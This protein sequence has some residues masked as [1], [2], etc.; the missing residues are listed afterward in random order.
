MGLY[1]DI[2]NLTQDEM[3]AFAKLYN[4]YSEAP[5]NYNI[6]YIYRLYR[7][8]EE[9]KKEYKA[10]SWNTV[11]DSLESMMFYPIHLDFEA[12]EQNFKH[13]RNMM[14]TVAGTKPIGG[15]GRLVCGDD[16]LLRWETGEELL[17]E[18]R[19]PVNSIIAYFYM[20]P[21]KPNKS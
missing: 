12:F 3:E 8:Y 14:N 18:E 20:R 7:K 10:L 15:G 13:H 1:I 17:A 16:N 21:N 5:Y 2:R 9:R 4:K 6:D 11:R 19:E